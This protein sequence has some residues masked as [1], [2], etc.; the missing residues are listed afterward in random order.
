M[1]WKLE[2][3]RKRKP[4]FKVTLKSKTLDLGSKYKMQD[5]VYKSGAK[6]GSFRVLQCFYGVATHSEECVDPQL[7]PG[8]TKN[9]QF[10][11]KEWY[12]IHKIGPP[13]K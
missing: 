4:D 1:L 8:V 7:L 9:K 6:Q 2:L 12:R 5:Y 3:K 10:F 11:P 13:P